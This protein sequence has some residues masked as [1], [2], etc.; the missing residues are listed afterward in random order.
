MTGCLF[1]GSSNI[2]LA[3]AKKWLHSAMVET[4]ID[5]MVITSNRWNTNNKANTTM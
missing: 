2:V 1:L 3:P 4:K 5:N